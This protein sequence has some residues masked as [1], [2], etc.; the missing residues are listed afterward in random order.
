M[1]RVEP[2]PGL[3][4]LNSTHEAIVSMAQVE[5]TISED[6]DESRQ[7][8]LAAVRSLSL[9]PGTTSA[10]KVG[11]AS[12]ACIE[13]GFDQPIVEEQDLDAL[14]DL[15]VNSE[16]VTNIPRL[17][18]RFVSNVVANAKKPLPTVVVGDHSRTNCGPKYS[19]ICAC[20]FGKVCYWLIEH[21][22]SGRTGAL[23]GIVSNDVY[24]DRP[25]EDPSALDVVDQ[26]DML[27]DEGD[28]L[29][30]E[31]DED[32]FEFMSLEEPSPYDG[33]PGNAASGLV[34]K[35]CGELVADFLC[36][37]S[38]LIDYEVFAGLVE[39]DWEQLNLAENLVRIAKVCWSLPEGHRLRRIA[40]PCITV[41]GHYVMH[42]QKAASSLVFRTMAKT[43]GSLI[44]LSLLVGDKRGML[45]L[46]SLVTCASLDGASIQEATHFYLECLHGIVVEVISA[47]LQG[48]KCTSDENLADLR[49][50][51]LTC[52]AFYIRHGPRQ[53]VSDVLLR[54]GVWRDLSQLSLSV[55]CARR[56]LLD[57]CCRCSSLAEFTL[58]VPGLLTVLKATE[59]EKSLGPSFLWRLLQST[60]SGLSAKAKNDQ[61]KLSVDEFSRAT[62]QLSA[63][64]KDPD[65]VVLDA[66][67][68]VLEKFQLMPCQVL[69]PFA[70]TFR[71]L[72]RNCQHGLQVLCKDGNAQAPEV[73][74]IVESDSLDGH[75]EQF[76]AVARKRLQTVIALVKQLLSKDSSGKSD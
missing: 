7:A 14:V 22:Q 11:S 9:G 27:E 13:L 75:A 52:L 38:S 30:S 44:D 18:R 15:F 53:A 10:E 19:K 65:L 54:C 66:V 60:Q 46:F 25:H 3:L 21:L 67:T 50:L 61:T 24:E 8:F 64:D 62:E 35:D 40:L 73:G 12:A 26:Q 76:H 68:A 59:E 20:L 16:A 55:D 23:S 42:K 17:S 34:E 57:G 69:E 32:D 6:D 1:S 39:Q 58:R 4:Q 74:T 72:Q 29:A 49:Q 31:Q 56:V 41:L 70:E 47:S 33:F 48:S 43:C 36:H 63:Q 5:G 45:E 71:V 37:C 51:A 28:V 2:A